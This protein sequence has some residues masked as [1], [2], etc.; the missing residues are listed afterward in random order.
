[1]VDAGAGERHAFPV[2]DG[3]EEIRARLR[4]RSARLEH[5]DTRELPRG[6]AGTPRRRLAGADVDGVVLAVR[7]LVPVDDEAPGGKR[8]RVV[9]E[10]L[11]L[12]RREPAAERQPRSALVARVPDAALRAPGVYALAVRSH[13]HLQHASGD[14]RRRGGP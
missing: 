2:P 1:P 13:A 9:V 12:G 8:I 11:D 6:T 3:R 7:G 4:S 5:A 10:L 14:V